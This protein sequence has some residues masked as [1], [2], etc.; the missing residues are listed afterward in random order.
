MKKGIFSLL[1]FTVVLL[2]GEILRE[3]ECVPTMCISS[4]ISENKPL[5]ANNSYLLRVNA[6]EITG[7]R[8]RPDSSYRLI[9]EIITFS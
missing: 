1:L 4:S 7:L 8:S 3:E 6:I 5:S 2:G 9:I